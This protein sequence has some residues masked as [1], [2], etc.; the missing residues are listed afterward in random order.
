MN[1]L[2]SAGHWFI[3]TGRDRKVYLRGINLGGDSKVPFPKGGTQF[4]DTF[5]NHRKVSFVG[6]PFPLAEAEEHFSRLKAWGFNCLRLLT[7]W[8]AVSHFGP[9][10]FDQEYLK[11]FRSVIE[12]A[13]RFGFYIFI[14]FHQDVWSR[15][16]G[17]DGAPGWTLEALGMDI[18]KISESDSAIVMQ[19]KYDYS[20]PGIRQE[21]NYP[22]MCWSQNYRYPANAIA[23][24]LFFAGKDF[25]PSF[26][27]GGVNVQDYLQGEYLSA[28][29][30]VAEMVADLPNVMGFDSLN[31][32]SRGW[33]GKRLSDRGYDV[34]KNIGFF[35]GPAWSPIDGLFSSMGYQVDLPYLELSLLRG[36]FTAK[37]NLTMNPKKIS[38]WKNPNLGDPFQLEGAWELKDEMPFILQ[39]DYFQKVGDRDVDFDRDYMI[40]FIHRVSD[41]IRS[42]RSDWMVFAEREA[43]ESVLSPKWVVDLPENSVNANHWYDLPTL[44]FKRFND[45]I[46]IHP[47][48]KHFV[49]GEKAIQ[50]MYE[51]QLQRIKE[52][53]ELQNV[54]T[55]LGE[56]GIPFD[57]QNGKAYKKWKSGNH[58]PKIWKKHTKA[59]SLMYAAIDNLQIH[60]TLWNYTASNSNDLM[61]GDNWNQEDLSI[62]S[63]DQKIPGADPGTWG[64]GGRAIGGF[65]R[66]Y[67]QKIQGG[68][69]NWKFDWK[70]EV[71]E[72][73]VEIAENDMESGL[74]SVLFIPEFHFPKNKLDLKVEM[75]EAD[76]FWEGQELSLIPKSLG[77]LAI[78]IKRKA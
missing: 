32:P 54:P 53:S 19:S 6:R 15:M 23:W 3:E 59:L 41:C 62:Y 45:P 56:F 77:P 31:E 78:R 35:P 8:E 38:L 51:S 48:E 72:F 18:S 71:F 74:P 16:T 12:I 37:R 66:P 21:E 34:S 68:N 7:T 28:M 5:E 57:L 69:P 10:Q 40:P 44:I 17:G 42:V 24:T 4:F 11:Y 20:R 26:K 64:D 33:I 73:S 75:G 47:L 61:V 29:R 70:D 50:K 76:I 36:G 46:T 63:P 55:L 30:A 9:S 49:F 58:S 14:D 52:A 43:M 65:C 39:D 13:E 60:S 2:K 27:I 22:T 25:A 67:P 1:K